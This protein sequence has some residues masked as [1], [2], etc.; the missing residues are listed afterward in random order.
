[1][2]W[3]NRNNYKQ[4][5]QLMQT[6]EVVTQ[7]AKNC[8]RQQPHSHLKSPPTGTHANIRIHLIFQETIVIGLHF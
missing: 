7:I 8:R 6:E 5:A 3:R 1:M 2:H 4:E